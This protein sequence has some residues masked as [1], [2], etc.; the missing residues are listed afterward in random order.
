MSYFS[1]SLTTQSV[2]W[3]SKKTGGS[4]KNKVGST[5]GKS[6]GWKKV[7]GSFVHRGEVLVKQLG[8]RFYPGENVCFFIYDLVDFFVLFIL[9]KLNFLPCQNKS[10]PLYLLFLFFFT[11]YLLRYCTNMYS[12]PV[13]WGC[14]IH[15]LHHCRW[16]RPPPT[17][18]CPGYD[19]KQSN[20]DAPAMLELREMQKT[21]SLP[22]LPGP[23]WLGVV[24]PDRAL[25]MGQIEPFDI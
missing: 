18:E 17:P 19:N 8:L 10:T 4:S 6:R 22:S 21:P 12:S 25:S 2:R 15:Q 20:G 14:R 23:L 5:P 13:G 7:E 16:V 9:Y 11:L 24:A 1:G 3:A